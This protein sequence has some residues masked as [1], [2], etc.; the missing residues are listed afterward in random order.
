[1]SMMQSRATWGEVGY[2]LLRLP[3]SLGR[4][5]PDGRGLER[6]V[7]G[8]TLPLYAGELPGGGP[9]INGHLL[10][11]RHG[12]ARAVGR[13]RPSCCC[14]PPRRSPGASRPATPPSPAGCCRRPA[15]AQ[16]QERVTQLEVSRERVVDAAEAEAGGSSVDLHD[17]AQQ[18]LVAVAMELGR[19]KAKF[20]DDVDAAAAL[21]DQ[22]H[23]RPRPRSSSCG[24]LVRGVHPP[25]LTRP[26]PRRVRLSGLAAQLPPS[27][28]PSRWTCRCGR[29]PRLEAVA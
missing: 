2:A 13:P 8:L 25:V 23:T 28:L 4:L 7:V 5:H 12:V 24:E 3:A 15:A 26:R 10:R 16:L 18:R 11:G 17:G 19:A 27:R 22:A 1:M 6:G 20:A 14:S 29:G 21:V 9:S